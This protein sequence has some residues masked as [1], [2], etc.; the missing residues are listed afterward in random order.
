MKLAIEKQ[1]HQTR[2]CTKVCGDAL[3]RTAVLGATAILHVSCFTIPPTFPCVDTL[4][5]TG[6]YFPLAK[7]CATATFTFSNFGHEKLFHDPRF[8][9]RS[10]SPHQ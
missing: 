9:N 1:T 4:P 8:E 7:Q 10:T 5:I 6:N 2:K 3:P